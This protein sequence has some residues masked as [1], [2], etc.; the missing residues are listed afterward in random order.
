MKPVFSPLALGLGMILMASAINLFGQPAISILPVN[1]TALE[2]QVLSSKQWQQISEQIQN[3]FVL[4]LSGKGNITKLSREHVLL[5]LKE[6]PPPEIENL[7]AEAYRIISKKE[8]LQYLVKCAVESIHVVDKNVI[9][10]I[11]VIIIDG[12]NGKI[13]WGKT[14]KVNKLL[15]TNTITDQLLLNE[16]YKPSVKE[17]TDQIRKLNL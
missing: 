7:D 3:Q 8:S 6:I 2:S 10:P 16:V 4:Q 9:S 1:T 11:R 12:S 17:L 14:L 5:L 15:P 13:F